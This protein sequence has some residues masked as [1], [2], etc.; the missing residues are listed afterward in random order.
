MAKKT[1]KKESESGKKEVEILC[2]NAAGKYH[3]PYNKGQKAELDAKQAD[4]MIEA[5]DAKEV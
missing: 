3:L 2:H 4:E 1:T 5:G